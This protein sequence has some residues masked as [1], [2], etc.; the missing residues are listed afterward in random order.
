M[1]GKAVECMVYRII[2]SQ[3]TNN[4]AA[5]AII[6]AMISH[7]QRTRVMPFMK[8]SFGSESV[9]NL[10]GHCKMWFL[11]VMPH[12]GYSKRRMRG[13]IKHLSCWPLA[14]TF[15][16]AT[17]QT[18]YPGWLRMCQARAC[19]LIC[20]SRFS[21]F[22]VGKTSLRLPSPGSLYSGHLEGMLPHGNTMKWIQ[23]KDRTM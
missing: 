10:N 12:R 22:G 1:D 21:C 11:P 20:W 14:A 18:I 5:R 17:G 23:E 3:A 13:I 19:S 8:M 15:E 4:T 7:C 6:S 16:T 9:V 2:C